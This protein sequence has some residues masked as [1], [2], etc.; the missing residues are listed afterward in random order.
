MTNCVKNIFG[1]SSEK[2]VPQ[3]KITKTLKIPPSTVHI[4]KRFRESGGV[5][6]R[7]GQG[8]RSKMAAHV[9]GTSGS[10][11]LKTGM[12]LNWTS[13]HRLRNTSKNRCEHCSLS[14]PQMQ[15]KAVSCKEEA[16][17]EH[18]PEM[19]VSPLGKSSTKMVWGK[20]ENCSV[21]RL[22]KIWN[23]FWKLWM[24]CPAD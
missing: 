12:V 15:V 18:D 2:S 24:S 5:S 10:T 11:A 6:V 13:L 7:K 3:H 14:H 17:G 23:S 19:P 20:M 22:I 4:I 21:V 16:R 1:T 8:W 9:L